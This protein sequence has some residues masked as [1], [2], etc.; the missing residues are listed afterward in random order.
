MCVDQ[1]DIVQ[2]QGFIE[3]IQ[4]LKYTKSQKQQKDCKTTKMLIGSL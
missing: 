4:L 3:F 1:L 2:G